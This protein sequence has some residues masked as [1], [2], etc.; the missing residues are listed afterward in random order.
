VGGW[1]NLADPDDVVALCKR[2]GPLFP[3]RDGGAGVQDRLVDN[4]EE[5]HADSRYLNAAPTGVALG[6]V[7]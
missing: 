4:G 7:L 3:A 5:P 1:V 6:G 2:L